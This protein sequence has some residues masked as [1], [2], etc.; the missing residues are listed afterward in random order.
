MKIEQWQITL[1]SSTW[2]KVDSSNNAEVL[3]NFSLSSPEASRLMQ[4]LRSILLEDQSGFYRLLL[5]SNV[6]SLRLGTADVELDYE[7]YNFRGELIQRTA[8]LTF[9]EISKHTYEAN[10][11]T[12]PDVSNPEVALFPKYDLVRQATEANRSD[13]VKVVENIS[14][15]PIGLLVNGIGKYN[16]ITLEHLGFDE[17]PLTDLEAQTIA[18]SNQMRAYHDRIGTI[19]TILFVAS[20]DRVHRTGVENFSDYG[21]SALRPYLNS[22]GRHALHLKSLYDL[23]KSINIPLDTFYRSGIK[24]TRFTFMPT[25]PLLNACH[26]LKKEVLVHKARYSSIS[27]LKLQPFEEMLQRAESYLES[28]SEAIVREKILELAGEVKPDFTSSVREANPWL[29]EY[30]IT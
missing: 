7:T 1:Q 9:D 26:A 17:I 29:A 21:F 23:S 18:I 12:Q 4:P 14:D 15:G 3:S 30:G 27:Y 8:T 20:R 5:E 10:G 19:E 13:Q 11:F 25:I 22:D 24:H 6:L 28:T 2:P 16:P